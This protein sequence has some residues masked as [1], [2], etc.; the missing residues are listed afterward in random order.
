MNPGNTII[1]RLPL[2]RGFISFTITP[3]ISVILSLFIIP[4]DS[5][6]PSALDT[7]SAPIPAVADSISQSETDPVDTVSPY[8]DFKPEKQ[9]A[10]PLERSSGEKKR[11]TDSLEFPDSLRKLQIVDSLL[12]IESKRRRQHAPDS[13]RSYHRV[14]DAGTIF[15]SDAGGWSDVAALNK[16]HTAPRTGI[17]CHLNRLLYMGN[18]APLTKVYAGTRL[19]YQTADNPLYGDDYWFASEFGTLR[20]DPSG[21][22]IC[23]PRAEDLSSPESEVFW[24]NGVFDENILLLR[25]TR[26]LSRKLRVN[27]FSNY[28][29]FKGTTFSHGGNDVFKTYSYLTRDTSLLSHE[30]YNPEVKEYFCGVDA[31][32]K[33]TASE[34]HMLVKYGDLLNELPINRLSRNAYPDITRLTQYPFSFSGGIYS[35]PGKRL[36]ADTEWEWLSRPQR[37]KPSSA[38]GSGNSPET[39]KKLIDRTIRGALRTGLLFRQSD[40]LSIGSNFQRTQVKV[41]DSLDLIS[42]RCRPEAAFVHPFSFSTPVSGTFSLSAGADFFNDDRDA[43]FAPVWNATIDASLFKFRSSIYFEQDLRHYAPFFDSLADGFTLHDAYL[44]SGMQVERSWA[45]FDLLVGYQWCYGIDSTAAERSWLSGT[46]PYRQPQSAVV[47]APAFGRWNGASLSTRLLLSDTR[48]FIKLQG[49]WSQLAFPRLTNEAFDI[50][51]EFDYWSERDPVSFAGKTDW[52]LPV[53]NVNFAA[54]AHIKSFR[55][56]YKVDNLLNRD[57]SYIPGYYAPGITF[58]WGFAWFIQR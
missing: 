53:I 44:R 6:P 48:P 47:I 3:R 15:R 46:A 8:T 30:G 33:G 1:T 52:N 41:A 2:P 16:M 55:L 51:L 21:N 18:T 31:H 49:A 14:I 26:P 29:Y 10:E 58:R 12:K 39:I 43:V 45:L 5:I 57:F 4:A 32:W 17:A 54:T 24:E 37:W 34:I 19:L 56:I 9:S 13:A 40:T 20:I 50:R 11:N 23:I 22:R 38:E 36:I 25:F 42:V 27:V 28:R 35:Q 7:L